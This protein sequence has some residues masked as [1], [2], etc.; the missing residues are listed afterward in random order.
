MTLRSDEGQRQVV[1]KPVAFA[2]GASAL[3]WKSLGMRLIVATD[4]EMKDRH[5]NYQRGLKVVE[6]RPGS[7]ADEEGIIEG[8]TLVAMHGWKT[9][10]LENLAYILQ[11][12]ENKNEKDCMFYILRDKEPFWGQMRV[13]NL[14][15]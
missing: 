8:D 14:P 6:V 5:P 4:S 12:T 1:L 15:R 7:P 2:T 11:Q 13:A 3:A 9:E 10:S